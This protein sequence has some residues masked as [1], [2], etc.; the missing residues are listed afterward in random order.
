MTGKKVAVVGGGLAG[1]AAAT[2]LAERGAD[3]T[4]LEREPILGGR[5][6]AH[7]DCLRD[8][9]TFDMERGFRVF[10]RHF[11]NVRALLRRIDP[12]LS[13]LRPLGDVE[14]LG[15]NGRRLS[16]SGLKTGAPFN[17][18]SALSRS[19]DFK[20]TDLM[21]TDPR[22]V[23][24]L[25]SFDPDRTYRELDG[26]SASEF[27]DRLRLPERLRETV[28]DVFAHSFFNPERE[29]SA[30]ELVAMFHFHFAGNAEGLG[31]DVSTEPFSVTI[32]KPLERY[33]RATGARI[34]VRLEIESLRREEGAWRVVARD[35]GIAKHFDVDGVVLATTVPSLKK[36]VASSPDLAPMAS[37]VASL[38]V[39]APYAIYRLWLDRPLSPARPAYARGHGHGPIDSIAILDRLEGESRRWAL[40]TGGSVVELHTYAIEEGKGEETVKTELKSALYA[41]YTESRS[42][43][44]ADE[45]FLFRRD[46]PAFRPGSHEARPR[47]ETSLRGVVL[48]GDF[49]KLPFPS[50]L[51]ERAVSSGFLAANALLAGFGLPTA[52]ISHGPARGLKWPLR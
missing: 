49:V 44:V 36:I 30:A 1:I 43:R 7:R 47:V 22:R 10:F 33:L 20:V 19:P 31:A 5:L 40:A 21:K 28:F 27:L 12:N 4:L 17:V 15:P 16:F 52:P 32:W 50:A 34:E 35:R 3:V 45:R 41:L 6:A 13:F 8:G 48:A 29:Y 39:T 18:L 9:T 42:A 25:L 26:I 51:M 14:L 11:K 23:L 24:A 38:D 46:S 2:M 37:S